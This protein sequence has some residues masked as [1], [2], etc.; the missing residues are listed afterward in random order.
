MPEEEKIKVVFEFADNDIISNKQLK[1]AVERKADEFF[2]KEVTPIKFKAEVSPDSTF[3]E[4][5]KNEISGERLF[6]LC[7]FL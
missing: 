5:F 7:K 1:I 3:A 6:E 4:I 2:K